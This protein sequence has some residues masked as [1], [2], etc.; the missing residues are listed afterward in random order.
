MLKLAESYNVSKPKTQTVSM[1]GTSGTISSYTIDLVEYS[2]G[3]ASAQIH[4]GAQLS[5]EEL[6]VIRDIIA[7]KISNG[8]ALHLENGRC[9]GV[10]NTFGELINLK[11]NFYVVN[12]DENNLHTFTSTVNH[13][14]L[15]SDT[16]VEYRHANMQSVSHPNVFVKFQNVY[17]MYRSNMLLNTNIDLVIIMPPQFALGNTPFKAVSNGELPFWVYS[18]VPLLTRAQNKV[19]RITL[20]RTDRPEVVDAFIKQTREFG[21]DIAVCGKES[22]YLI[23]SNCYMQMVAGVPPI[24]YNYTPL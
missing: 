22:Q 24:T 13:T 10:Y 9:C 3:L 15:M 7:T 21:L 1:L 18:S 23:A 14:L 8:P 20:E 12:H 11:E 19:E 16:F 2:K 17:H 4:G 5:N 6:N